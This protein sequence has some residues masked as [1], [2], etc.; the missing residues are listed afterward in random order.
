[1]STPAAPQGE[2]RTTPTPDS[3]KRPKQPHAE[4][5]APKEK[6]SAKDKDSHDKQ[7]SEQNKQKKPM[8]PRTR[9]LLIAGGAVVVLGAAGYWFYGTFY[10][11]T[12][13]AQIDGYISNIAPR[14]GGT[15]T[16]VSVDDNQTV[17]SGKVLVQLDPTD[18]RVARDQARAALAQAEA[19]LRAEQ[20]DTSVTEVTNKTQ[21]ATSSS[22]VASGYAGVAEAQQSVAQANAQIKQAEADSQLADTEKQ[23]AEQLLQSGAIARAEYDNR[24]AA[25][26]AAAAKLDAQR[27]GVEAARKRVDEE[28][29]KASAA[30]DRF[31]EAKTNGP[32]VLEGKR[33]TV[34]LRKASVDVAR[35]Q[36]EQA[37]LNLT[38][39]TISAPVKGVVGK[40]SVNVGDRVTAGQSLLGITQTDKLWVT[41]D[42]RETQVRRMHPGEH[43]TLH[44]DALGRD[45]EG[46]VESIAAATGS[47]YSVLPPENASGNYV[48][49]VQR[50]PVRIRLN[51]GQAGLELLRPG[52]SVEPKVRVK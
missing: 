9:A 45:F 49:V 46:S 11:E 47:R 36:L 26:E 2:E 14:V 43:A 16:A 23:R 32:Q 13:D 50:L 25:A 12:D 39:A 7:P 40:R 41:A 29:A 10:E 17:E 24:V 19:Q 42:F 38:Y 44:V 30:N 27:K 52:M 8:S 35:A 21:V 3:A 31:N 48:K 28:A 51:P 6:D 22:D 1:M 33:A 4:A 34:D 20:S 15:V 5:E 37:E 18:L